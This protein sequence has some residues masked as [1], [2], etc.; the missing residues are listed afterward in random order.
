[1]PLLRTLT[2]RCALL[3]VA[4]LRACL[5]SGPALGAQAQPARP[6]L[7]RL[8]PCELEHPLGITAVAA[9]CGILSVAENLEVPTGRQ[10]ELHVARV[11]AVSRRKLPDALFILAGG[12][13]QA[14]TQFYAGTAAAFARIQRDRDI[15][16]VDQRGTGG[17]HPLPCAALDDATLALDAPRI[18]QAAR[19]CAQQLGASA[20]L[21]FFTTSVAVQDLDR[22]R[23]AL[24]YGRVNL[25]GISY[26]TRIA[27]HYLRRFPQHARTVILD[28]V[29]APTEY[30]GPAMALDAE[31]A[32]GGIF[33]RCTHDDAC[34]EHFGDPHGDYHAL[35]AAVSQTPVAVE[36]AD[37]GTG[38][39]TRLNFSM[40]QLA[41]VLR[42]S[43]YSASQASLLPLML[44]LAQHDGNFA[45]LAAQFLAIEG[46]LNQ[47][48]AYGMH[49]SVVCTEDA[50][51]YRRMR[52]DRAAL[53]QTY[54]GTT[55]I[56][57]L[58]IICRVWPRGIMDPDFHEP[59]HSSVPAL[60]L[61]GGNDPA[62][63]KE[64][65][66]EAARGFSDR[67][68]VIVPEQGHGQLT[69]PCVDD[70]MARFITAGTAKNLDISCVTEDRPAPFFT[71]L[72][73]PAP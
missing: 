1:M 70:I 19:Q 46:S 31:R 55:Q 44:H 7:L 69:T 63:P 33:A 29:V 23:A 14:A 56:D 17:S 41:T 39:T 30:L 48:L 11:P 34:R 60:L 26:G 52:I 49:N 9:E 22:V 57:A 42:L 72:A 21:R 59:M 36:L 15:V 66:V 67:A 32:L 12:P 13:G 35:R 54:L 20:D 64:N 47:Q 61:S 45:P 50:P 28:G 6:A 8:A 53:E 10:I 16:L 71:S 40:L 68:H 38:A 2:P 65:A 3:L 18:E 25:Y 37:P 4:L 27:Q 43:T 51:F 5:T 58:E 73:G 24:G 62:T